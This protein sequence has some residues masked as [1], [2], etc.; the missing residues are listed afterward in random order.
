MYVRVEI[1][2]FFTFVR[3]YSFYVLFVNF[4][5]LVFCSLGCSG[6]EMGIRVEEGEG[7]F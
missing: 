4:E 1:W 2:K 7:V 6:V 5:S 3:F